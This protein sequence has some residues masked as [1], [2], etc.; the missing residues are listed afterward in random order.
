MILLYLD[1]HVAVLPFLVILFMHANRL[2]I[3][4]FSPDN[5]TLMRF[6]GSVAPSDSSALNRGHEH[7]RSMRRCHARD[8]RP[9]CFG[10]P[11]RGSATRNA[12]SSRIAQ[13]RPGIP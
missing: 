11:P 7:Q 8:G 2:I 4:L 5:A 3:K 12:N 1:D 10:G 9:R 13:P 6:S